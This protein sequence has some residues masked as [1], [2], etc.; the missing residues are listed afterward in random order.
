M[1]EFTQYP[2]NIGDLQNCLWLVMDYPKITVS[3]EEIWMRAKGS[4]TVPNFS[5]VYI[6]I[7]FER[8]A[9]A[10]S[11]KY[12]KTNIRYTVNMRDSV[13]Y[14]DDIA[15]ESYE[16]MK[17][18]VDTYDKKLNQNSDTDEEASISISDDN[19]E[20]LKAQSDELTKAILAGALNEKHVHHAVNINQY[21]IELK[22]DLSPIN[23]INEHEFPVDIYITD[24]KYKHLG[25]N[26]NYSDLSDL[27]RDDL[28]GENDFYVPI[29]WIDDEI[30]AVTLLNFSGRSDILGYAV[31]RPSGDCPP[32]NCLDANGKLTEEGVTH[33]TDTIRNTL[34]CWNR[35]IRGEIYDVVIYEN[36]NIVALCGGFCDANDEELSKNV[37]FYTHEIKPIIFEEFFDMTGKVLEFDIMKQKDSWEDYVSEIIFRKFKDTMKTGGESEN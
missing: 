31:Y 36:C 37:L 25:D 27:Y 14:V 9:I 5:N 4:E 1:L 22:T 12:P 24:P 11:L 2:D 16:Q 20:A 29:A 15:I 21:R 7:V 28:I 26:Y 6:S 30:L 17:K 10:L 3:H 13:F 23:P 32:K 33:A 8:L 18:I 34:A 19:D 35:Y